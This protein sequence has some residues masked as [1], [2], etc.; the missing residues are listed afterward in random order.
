M[1]ITT[2]LNDETQD[3]NK[4][5]IDVPLTVTQHFERKQRSAAW[6]SLKAFQAII[7]IRYINPININPYETKQE[8]KKKDLIFFHLF[9]TVNEKYVVLNN[10]RWPG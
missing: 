7:Q 3:R 5:L 9:R 10:M 2:C 4:M 8:R 1:K 6:A